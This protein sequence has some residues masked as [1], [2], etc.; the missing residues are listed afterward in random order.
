VQFE[1]YDA[2]G[3]DVA[4]YDT[5]ASNSGGVYRSNAVDIKGDHRYRRRLSG[6]GGRRPVSG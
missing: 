4:Y 5:T 2:G 6:G 3:A 1:N